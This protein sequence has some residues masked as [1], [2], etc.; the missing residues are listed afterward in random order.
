MSLQILKNR[1]ERS[2][3][4]Q[5]WRLAGENQISVGSIKVIANQEEGREEERMN[6]NRKVRSFVQR[7]AAKNVRTKNIRIFFESITIKTKLSKLVD[8]L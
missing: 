4:R 5:M 8:M 6:E 3:G 1:R 7:N 2:E